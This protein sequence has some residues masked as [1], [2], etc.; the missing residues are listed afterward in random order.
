MAASGPVWRLPKPLSTYAV[1][2]D[3]DTYITVRRH[4]TP[5][6]ERLFFCHGN[7]LAIDLYYPFWS[8]FES[9]F[10]IFLYDLRNHGW[11][12]PGSLD[13]HNVPNMADDHDRVIEAI[14]LHYG[15]KPTVGVFH[16]VSAMAALAS[17]T[18]GIGYEALILFD[19]P[20][21]QPGRSYEE[22]ET[23]AMR[24]TAST[25]RRTEHF[26]SAEQLIE[27][28]SVLPLYA[29][30]VP[31]VWELWARTTLR[32]RGDGEGYELRCPREYEARIV[33]FASVFAIWINFSSMKCPVKVIGADP[34]LPFSF[35]PTLELSDVLSV[36]YDFLPDA[37]HWL[38][39]EQPK[40]C[41]ALTREFMEEIRFA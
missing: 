12:K 36:D 32:D 17:P 4:G 38:Q 10:D 18:K 7:G 26:D 31:G 16:S 40:E 6:G 5:G 25:L 28:L 19:P 2:V 9:E 1:R 3:D 37:T 20:L 34:T 14:N 21:C 39:L 30:T 8:L 41:A 13:R 24:A 33:E 22:F 29:R 11:N 35:L 27:V 15:P 23:A